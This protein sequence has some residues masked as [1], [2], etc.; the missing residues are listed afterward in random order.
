[1]TTRRQSFKKVLAAAGTFTAGVSALQAESQP[2]M[3]KALA[4]LRNAQESLKN[5]DADKGGHRV[6]AMKLIAEAISEVEQ[7]IS[8]DNR[9]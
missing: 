4:A 1:M 8:F 3:R 7:G 2:Y 5:A 9:H 6:K